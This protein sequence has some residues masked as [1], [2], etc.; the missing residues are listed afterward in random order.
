MKIFQVDA[1]S[2]RLYGGNPAAVV[3]LKDWLDDETMQNIAAEN[4]LS[5]TAFFV[6]QNEDTY[7]L[8]WFTPETEVDLCG[9]ATLA[10]AHVLYVHMDYEHDFVHFNTKS[11]MLSVEKVDGKYKMNFPADEIEEVEVSP[12]LEVCFD[13]VPLRVFKGRSDYLFVFDNEDNVKYIRPQLLAIE[14]LTDARGVIITSPSREL[15]FVSRFFAPQCGVNEDPVTGSSFTT[16]APFWAKELG[17][18]SFIAK[19]ISKR[20]GYVECGI[21]NNRVEIKGDAKTYMIGE[22]QELSM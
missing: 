12:A 7:G 15:D 1:F 16:L 5:E 8:R 6:Q 3:P 21:S 17:K 10:S 20:G 19:Q 18:R 14:R 2:T 4:N 13:R 11:G 22:I 9:H